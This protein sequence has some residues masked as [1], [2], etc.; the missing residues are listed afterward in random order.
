MKYSLLIFALGTTL[1][2]YAKK[3]QDS[4]ELITKAQEAQLREEAASYTTIAD[5]H[6]ASLDGFFDDL[7]TDLENSMSED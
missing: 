2:T 3:R 4:A 5:R 1:T 7:K 6:V